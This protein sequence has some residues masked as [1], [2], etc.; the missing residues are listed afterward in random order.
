MA[1]NV[2]SWNEEDFWW[3]NTIRV[4]NIRSTF[5]REIEATGSDGEAYTITIPEP[6]VYVIPTILTNPIREPQEKKV[7]DIATVKELL[8]YIEKSTEHKIKL[9]EVYKTLSVKQSKIVE[10]VSKENQIILPLVPKFCTDY[11]ANETWTDQN[12][13]VNR[14]L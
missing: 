4:I 13:M 8:Y 10:Q 14:L 12:N 3:W 5:T 9:N 6:A 7:K 11:F 2:K 1:C